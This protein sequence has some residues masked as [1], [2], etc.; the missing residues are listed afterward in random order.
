MGNASLVSGG[1]DQVGGEIAVGGIPIWK[2]PPKR[3]LFEVGTKARVWGDGAGTL[4]M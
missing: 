3:V 1:D 4:T 2:Y